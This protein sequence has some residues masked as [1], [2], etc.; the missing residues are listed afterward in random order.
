[1]LFR[2]NAVE[3]K[4]PPLRHRREDIPY[5]TAAFVA[6]CARRLK[7]PVLG[8]T[9]AAE[10]MLSNQVWDGNVREL[11][12]TIE[13]ACMLA[14]GSLLTD[15]DVTRDN[16]AGGVAEE[17]APEGLVPGTLDGMERERIVDVLRTVAGNKQAAARILGVS[18]RAFYRRLERY[19]LHTASPTASDRSTRRER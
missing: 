7:K 6:D 18:R 4:L 11:R 14:E 3:V 19:G 16:G 9:P 8:V 2:L 5:L 15:R 1:L 17:A 13:R 10:R 12:N